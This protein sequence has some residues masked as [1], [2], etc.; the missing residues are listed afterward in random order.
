M[1]L[2]ILFQS[3]ITSIIP[4]TQLIT[5]IVLIFT[6]FITFKEFQRSNKVRKQ[7]VY[8]RLELAS[9]DLFKMA[10]DHPELRKIYDE[11]ID[12]NLTDVEKGRLREYTSSL[13]NLFEIHFNLRLS[14]DIEPVIFATWMPWLYD[15][16]RSSYFRDAWKDLQR[17]Y[18]PE[19]RKFINSLIEAIDIVDEPIKEER[20][21]EKASHLLKD[22]IIKNWL[23]RSKVRRTG[24]LSKEQRRLTERIRL[25]AFGTLP[26]SP[27]GGLQIRSKR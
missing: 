5:A 19:F 23:T 3:V 18:V 27:F 14:K 24:I 7:D 12:E 16:C 15:I 17:H 21:Y 4:I 22:D 2:F 6:L 1:E 9:I 20:F 10:I 26:K 25:R 8:T 13:L 11:Q